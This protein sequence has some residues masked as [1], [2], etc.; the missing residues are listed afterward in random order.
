MD[1]DPGRIFT[2]LERA[3]AHTTP[4]RGSFYN[5]PPSSLRS[6]TSVLHPFYARASICNIPRAFIYETPRTEAAGD[7]RRRVNWIHSGPEGSCLSQNPD[8]REKRERLK[9]SAFVDRKFCASSAHSS[10]P[11]IIRI[12]LDARFKRICIH[13]RAIAVAWNITWGVEYRQASEAIK[14][15]ANYPNVLRFVVST[16]GSVYREIADSRCRCAL[17]EA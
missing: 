5:P 10:S 3:G 11:R 13:A 12:F 7:M 2:C 16:V 1:D 14:R 4:A 15:V 8:P 17:F 6:R 9:N